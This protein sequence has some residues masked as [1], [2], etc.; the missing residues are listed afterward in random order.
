MKDTAVKTGKATFGYKSAP[1][2]FG[3]EKLTIYYKDLDGSFWFYEDELLVLFR[4]PVFNDFWNDVED[5]EVWEVASG[6][7]PGEMVLMGMV[8]LKG[9]YRGVTGSMNFNSIAFNIFIDSVWR[10]FH[11]DILGEPTVFESMKKYGL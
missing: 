9:F 3:G 8:S 7:Y 1:F 6:D 5:G 10:I 2:D 4:D 11:Q